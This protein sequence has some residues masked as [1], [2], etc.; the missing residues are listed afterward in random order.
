MVKNKPQ[1]KRDLILIASLVL[2][3]GIIFILYYS[4]KDEPEAA[5]VSYESIV[6]FELSMDNGK[7]KQATETFN[8]EFLPEIKEDKLFIDNEE[9]TLLQEGYGVLKFENNYFVK[10]KLGFVHIEYNK[11]TKKIRVVEETSPYNI[12]SNQGY[13]NN[14]PIVCLPNY[15]SIKFSKSEVD[16]IL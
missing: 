5:I 15:I 12:C 11:T 13:S 2:I 14:A 8:A 4:L 10:G 9:F 3:V 7:Y 1:L 16:E 6:L